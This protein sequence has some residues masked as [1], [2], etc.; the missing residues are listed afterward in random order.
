MAVRGNFA[1]LENGLIT[2][3]RAGRI[4]TEKNREIIA[5]LRE[6][7]KKI[8]DVEIGLYPGEEHRFV[9]VLTGD[10]PERPA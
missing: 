2:D 1:T 3:R 5:F 8:E 7:I 4:P 9:L 10:G 6:K